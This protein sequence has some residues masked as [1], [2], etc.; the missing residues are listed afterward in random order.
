[1]GDNRMSFDRRNGLCDACQPRAL[2]F[3]DRMVDMGNKLD[4]LATA[5]DCGDISSLEELDR[6]ADDAYRLAKAFDA[7]LCK[8]CK[9]LGPPCPKRWTDC[10]AN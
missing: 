8:E 5:I 3:A 6:V 7:V 2:P 1:M 9:K 10:A 4:A